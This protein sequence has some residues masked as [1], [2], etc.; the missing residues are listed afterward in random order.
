M[1]SNSRAKGNR[2]VRRAIDYYTEKGWRVDKVEK[3]GKFIIEKDLFGLFDLVGI[4]KNQVVFIQVKTNKPA[5]Q[6]AYK[7]FSKCY[8]GRH[9]GCEVFTWY[10]RR[11]PVVQIYKNTGKI[12][13]NDMRK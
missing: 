12:I 9:L 2:S 7:E 6:Q 13:K 5:T 8:G 4:R 1:T 3:T 10:D 11:G